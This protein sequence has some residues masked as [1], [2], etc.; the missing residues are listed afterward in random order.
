MKNKFSCFVFIAR[1]RKI[2]VNF[3]VVTITIIVKKT[4]KITVVMTVMIDFIMIMFKFK[5]NFI[6]IEKTAAITTI[7][8]NY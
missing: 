7:N 3:K 2:I 6:I 4:T 8:S 5:F 1:K